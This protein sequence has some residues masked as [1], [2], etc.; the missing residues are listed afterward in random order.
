MHSTKESSRGL[1]STF[2][3]C[4]WPALATARSQGN[5]ENCMAIIYSPV[6]PVLNPLIYSL[7]NKEVMLALKKTLEKKLYKDLQQQ[8]QDE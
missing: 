8:Q 1:E 4:S 3:I 5:H 7:R 2:T 6:T